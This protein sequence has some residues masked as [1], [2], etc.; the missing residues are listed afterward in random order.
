MR[1]CTGP[2]TDVAFD[3]VHDAA[4][5]LVDHV[6]DTGVAERAGVER[7]AAGRR[8]EGGAIEHDAAAPRRV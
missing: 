7:L 1:P 2:G 5:V 3:D 4:V 6:D 8:I